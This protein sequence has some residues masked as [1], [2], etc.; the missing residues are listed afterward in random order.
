MDQK[1][2]GHSPPK[3]VYLFSGDGRR[4]SVGCLFHAF[5][6]ESLYDYHFSGPAG[7]PTEV[8]FTAAS[9]DSGTGVLWPA[10]SPYVVGVGG[11]TL[12][13]DNN[14]NVTEAAW[15]GSGGGISA[16]E[17]EPTYQ[18][19]YGV[20]GGGRRGVPDVSYVADPNTGVE[21]YDST[22]YNGQIGWFQV[23][24]TSVGS[25][26][27][28]ALAVLADQ[29]RAA[30]SPPRPSLYTTQSSSPFYYAA[31]DT[32]TNPNAYASNYRDITTGSNG[33]KHCQTCSATVG[34]DFVTG[35][36]SPL[37]NNLVPF[38]SGH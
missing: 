24:G 32:V 10:A 29:A 19:S 37:S 17:S 28:A 14:G 3:R 35:L 9:G 4:E 13:L 16:Y 2:G 26:Q 34:Y 1:A 18:T 20:L 30:G 11:T 6:G 25:P 8:T 15:S 7:T 22:P 38:L 5:S 23:G 27:W 31:T 21:V 12:H 36:G 33:G